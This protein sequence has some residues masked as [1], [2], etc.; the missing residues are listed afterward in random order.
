M[1][2]VRGRKQSRLTERC[3]CSCRE[4]SMQQTYEALSCE[5]A[6]LHGELKHQTG[7]IRK[8]RPLVGETR[9]G[10]EESQSHEEKRLEEL[11][12]TQHLERPNIWSQASCS[13]PKH[14]RELQG[15]EDHETANED[16]NIQDQNQDQNQDQDQ[17]QNQ[18]QDPDRPPAPLR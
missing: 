5:V 7:L 13:A 11:K 16:K 14:R 15:S 2:E 6:R 12:E 9:Q 10:L 17:D 1:S 3:R 18:N 4:R 8:L